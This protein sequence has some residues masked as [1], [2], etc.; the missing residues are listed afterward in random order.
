[1]SRYCSS[2]R[3]L[4]GSGTSTFGLT[5]SLA[6]NCSASLRTKSPGK[7]T[8]G[9]C[10]GGLAGVACAQ[11]DVASTIAVT[12]AAAP[13]AAL[14]T[15]IA[16]RL[17]CAPDCALLMR[18]FSLV[19]PITGQLPSPC[20]LRFASPAHPPQGAVHHAAA[21]PANEKPPRSCRALLSTGLNSSGIWQLFLP[22]TI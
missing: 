12:A 8:P 2:V 17:G 7:G 9:L 15:I 3:L 16:R 21:R 11:A 22:C 1:M 6:A 13:Q 10:G 14:P 5:Y 20:A 4:K 19:A 18:I